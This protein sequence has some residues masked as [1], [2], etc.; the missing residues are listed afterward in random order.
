MDWQQIESVLH[1]APDGTYIGGEGDMLRATFEMRSRVFN[2]FSITQFKD[3]AAEKSKIEI[4][5]ELER[6]VRLGDVDKCRRMIN[7]HGIAWFVDLHRS[8]VQGRNPF[9][10][11]CLCS[12]RE[13]I[14]FFIK[15]LE[16]ALSPGICLWIITQNSE[17]LAEMACNPSVRPLVTSLRKRLLQTLRSE[18]CTSSGDKSARFRA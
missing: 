8:N 18:S 12:R 4:A 3:H 15:V 17:N 10:M 13:L 5:D 9:Y 2:P 1:V 16:T 11:A 7:Y 14:Q 6:F